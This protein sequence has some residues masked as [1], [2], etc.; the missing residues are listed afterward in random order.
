MDGEPDAPTYAPSEIEPLPEVFDPFTFPFYLQIDE[1]SKSFYYSQEYSHLILNEDDL[2]GAQ[3]C[4][5]CYGHMLDCCKF[6]N[7]IHTVCS[8]CFNDMIKNNNYLCPVCR[9]PFNT[10]LKEGNHDLL[11]KVIFQCPHKDLNGCDFQGTLELIAE[12]I[13]TCQVA[14]GRCGVLVPPAGVSRHFLECR[15]MSIRKQDDSLLTLEEFFGSIPDWHVPL[16]VS[17]L[18]MGA[19]ALSSRPIINEPNKNIRIPVTQ[20]TFSIFCATF[21]A[22]NL[23]AFQSIVFES[24]SL[25]ILDELAAQ[26]IL[27]LLR[28]S[29]VVALFGEF[30]FRTRSLCD[31]FLAA[32]ANLGLGGPVR[33]IGAPRGIIIEN[34]KGELT[35]F[36]APQL[37]KF[38]SLYVNKV[39]SAPIKSSDMRT[40][41]AW[42][43]RSSVIAEFL[44]TNPNIDVISVKFNPDTLYHLAAVRF[45]ARKETPFFT[46][47]KALR[48][49]E[50]EPGQTA[51]SFFFRIASETV[52]HFT[53]LEQLKLPLPTSPNGRFK[54]PLLTAFQSIFQQLQ[55]PNALKSIIFNNRWVRKQEDSDERQFE[56]RDHKPIVSVQPLLDVLPRFPHLTRL[57]FRHCQIR[58]KALFLDILLKWIRTFPLDTAGL[59]PAQRPEKVL[60]MSLT[61]LTVKG[62]RMFLQFVLQADSPPIKL[63]TAT[64]EKLLGIVSGQKACIKA[65]TFKENNLS[66]VLTII[67]KFPP[68]F[69]KSLKFINLSQFNARLSH[70]IFEALEALVDHADVAELIPPHCSNAEEYFNAHN[71]LNF[72]ESL[73]PML[74]KQCA[75]FAKFA[76]RT[77][78][79]LSVQPADF[80]LQPIFQAVRKKLPFLVFGETGVSSLELFPSVLSY[81][82]MASVAKRHVCQYTERPSILHLLFVLDEFSRK[83]F[84]DHITSLVLPDIF[85]WTNG[86]TDKYA[87]L[88][89]QTLR[90][91]PHLRSLTMRLGVE[92]YEMGQEQTSSALM[93]FVEAMLEARQRGC[94]VRTTEWL[95]NIFDNLFGDTS[96]GDTLRLTGVPP[97]VYVPLFKHFS[98]KYSFPNVT[99]LLLS[100]RAVYL[101]PPT[102]KKRIHLIRSGLTAPNFASLL[103]VLTETDPEKQ[104]FPRLSAV[105]LC[106]FNGFQTN[107]PEKTSFKLSRH[108]TPDAPIR[109]FQEFSETSGAETFLIADVMDKLVSR[110]FEYNALNATPAPYAADASPM[111]LFREFSARVGQFIET[112]GVAALG[113]FIEY[114]NHPGFDEDW[115]PRRL[116]VR[117]KRLSRTRCNGTSL[118]RNPLSE[119][120]RQVLHLLPEPSPPGVSPARL[121]HAPFKIRTDPFPFFGIFA[122]IASEPELETLA[123]RVLNGQHLVPR[124]LRAFSQYFFDTLPLLTHLRHIVLS[125]AVPVELALALLEGVDAGAPRLEA[126]VAQA[127]QLHDTIDNL[128]VDRFALFTGRSMRM[129]RT[130]AKAA[131]IPFV[132]LGVG[133]LNAC[134][135]FF[136]APAGRRPHKLSFFARDAQAAVLELLVFTEF[137]DDAFAGVKEMTVR[138]PV[139]LEAAALPMKAARA[140]PDLRRFSTH[141]VRRTYE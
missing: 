108:T 106:N 34:K 61:S 102:S 3:C 137:S 119:R 33:N 104:L 126:F 18:G 95:Q 77:L 72:K 20:D 53:C 128:K 15:P 79:A 133:A 99:Q 98:G 68:S 49:K 117:E 114:T 111:R 85:E 67:S 5:I 110:R 11:K 75:C 48:F 115:T 26:A 129:E 39:Y 8:S 31:Q 55:N 124:Q 46:R 136:K 22:A 57:R 64:L 40:P 35:A 88:F 59:H 13:E 127:V 54:K 78:F 51:S 23:V 17:T 44:S 116:L 28:C 113:E 66:K 6:Q 84:L 56:A 125:F 1:D 71:F 29:R 43:S 91:L 109:T 121:A 4:S 90:Q 9:T 42:I 32:L 16:L 118:F 62:W 93:S 69:L 82:E 24:T 107:S 10:A 100:A 135:Q 89:A 37:D 21:T 47:V 50:D 36:S 63:H 86:C 130:L 97:V 58:E 140:L 141:C 25:T 70:Q 45:L 122:D 38:L 87:Q 92:Q 83:G 19:G 94:R 74:Y 138:A 52:R 80:I 120:V 139:A 30:R 2:V 81:P 60:R 12:H 101:E 76:S 112:H 41:L 132:Q 103:D 27:Q 73:E 105:S 14:C 7:C 65:S 134:V 123:L 96:A 131:R